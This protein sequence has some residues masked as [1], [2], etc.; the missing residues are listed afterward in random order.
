MSRST[1]GDV[2]LASSIENVGVTLCMKV[3][4]KQELG[5]MFK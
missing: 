5:I 4:M 2:N 3:P 1:S